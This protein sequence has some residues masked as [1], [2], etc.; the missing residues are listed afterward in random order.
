MQSVT[1]F[2]ESYEVEGMEFLGV[3]FFSLSM[4]IFLG[5]IPRKAFRAHQLDHFVALFQARGFGPPSHGWWRGMGHPEKAQRLWVHFIQMSGLTVEK[6][7][8]WGCGER[9]QGVVPKVKARTLV[10]RASDCCAVSSAC[11]SFTPREV[12]VPTL[13][14]NN[15]SQKRGLFPPWPGY[16]TAVEHLLC[17]RPRSRIWGPSSAVNFEVGEECPR[18]NLA[19]AKAPGCQ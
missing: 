17:A 13:D 4:W 1:P 6:M 9:S 16:S 3:F 18:E 19:S 7:R 12:A 8:V 2:H 5:H 15:G 10:S 14:E 11:P